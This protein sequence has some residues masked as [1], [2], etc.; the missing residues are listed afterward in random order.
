M[1]LLKKIL[2]FFFLSTPLL[3]FILFGFLLSNLL[4]F[5]VLKTLTF[6]FLSTTARY[7]CL[8]VF[9]SSPTVPLLHSASSPAT[10]FLL[11]SLH[12]YPLASLTFNSFGPSITIDKVKR[13]ENR[14]CGTPG[15]S[16]S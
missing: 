6:L 9:D 4:L 12:I 11:N 7:H 16:G 8:W 15:N 13:E 14:I 10:S 1:S 3:V 2:L 5:P